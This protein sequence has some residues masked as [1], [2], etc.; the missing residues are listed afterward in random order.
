MRKG[1]VAL[2]TVAALFAIAAPGQATVID[3]EHYSQP[4]SDD[5]TACGFSIHL[6]GLATGNARN[7]G[8]QARP[9]YRVFRAR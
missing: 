3:H 9:R 1:F 7:R 2:G 8:G 4:F 6:E 5:F